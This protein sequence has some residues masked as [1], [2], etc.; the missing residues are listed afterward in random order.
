MRK[1]DTSSDVKR[2]EPRRGSQWQ[3][4]MPLIVIIV[5]TVLAAC[6]KQVSYGAGSRWIS[7]MHDFMGF[8]LLVFSMFKLFDLEGFA[9]GFQMYDLLAKHV[10]AYAYL[11][12]FI[13]LALGLGYLAHWQPKLIYLVTLIVMTFGG[14][15]VIRALTKR[16]DI[17]C[18]CLGT[19]LSVPLSTVAV[20][21]DL[22]M[23]GMAATMLVSGF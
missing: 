12:A 7:W 18:A 13:E 9:D 5:L 21:E 10:R 16:L 23:A 3:D 6:A 14:L 11:Y 19:V 8:F 17:E 4:Y 2:R 15:G 22:G 20:I 1:N